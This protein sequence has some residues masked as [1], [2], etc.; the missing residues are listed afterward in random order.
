MSANRRRH[1]E[2]DTRIDVWI[3]GIGGTRDSV[4]DGQPG[5]DAFGKDDGRVTHVIELVDGYNGDTHKFHAEPIDMDGDLLK[6]R[7]AEKHY[8]IAWKHKDEVASAIYATLPSDEFFKW[9]R[10]W[11]SEAEQARRGR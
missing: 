8:L 3:V 7:S 1:D 10:T 5:G 11:E 2:T 4:A 9:L 6:L